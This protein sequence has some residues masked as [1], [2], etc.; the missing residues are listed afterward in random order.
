MLNEKGNHP[1]MEHLGR[2]LGDDIRLVISHIRENRNVSKMFANEL[3]YI[4]NGCKPKFE[5]RFK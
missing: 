3:P 2:A 1:I 4:F 5:V